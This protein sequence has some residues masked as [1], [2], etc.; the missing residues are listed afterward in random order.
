M[1]KVYGGV[2]SP[3]EQPQ[4]VLK[5]KTRRVK[6]KK[7]NT[8]IYIYIYIYVYMYVIHYYLS[9]SPRSPRPGLF[10]T[11]GCMS[12]AYKGGRTKR[13]CSQE[14]DLRIGFETGPR[15]MYR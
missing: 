11:G 7:I 8:Y 13:R 14:P 15:S 12:D 5:W 2:P 9:S 6:Q 3:P 10:A 4:L 1:F